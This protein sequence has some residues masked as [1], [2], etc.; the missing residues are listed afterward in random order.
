MPGRQQRSRRVEVVLCKRANLEPTHR[1][2]IATSINDSQ[3]KPQ[4]CASVLSSE[5]LDAIPSRMAADTD[6]V[7][8]V[9]KHWQEF[10]ES[11]VVGWTRTELGV[12][13]NGL[14]PCSTSRGVAQPG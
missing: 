12:V 9:D 8:S 14:I 10:T 3:R 2:T 11:I 13:T 4:G 5:E 1:P 6:R 7:V